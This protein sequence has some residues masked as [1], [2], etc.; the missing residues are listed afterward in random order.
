MNSVGSMVP[1]I[2]W[3]T[4][5]AATIPC[6]MLDVGVRAIQQLQRRSAGVAS[7]P[8]LGPVG[9]FLLSLVVNFLL[10]LGLA[11]LYHTLWA[12][13]GRAFL[14]GGVLWLFL[15]LPV[16]IM[17]NHTDDVQKRTLITWLLGWLFKLGATSAALAYFIT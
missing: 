16:L 12:G 9:R 10:C 1:E 15:A 6:V 4:A 5:A 2:L 8:S 17:L 11:W 7:D 14:Y 3:I 13:S